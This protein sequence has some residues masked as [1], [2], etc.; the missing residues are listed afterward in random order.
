MARRSRG[1]TLIELVIAITILSMLSLLIY[2]AFSGMRRTKDGLERVGDRYRE[3][4]VAMARIARD[5]QSAYVSLH[6]PINPSLTVVKTAFIATSGT[7]ADRLDFNS[8]AN[9]RR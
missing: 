7:P 6:V 8:F 3:G 9:L 2:G 1:F 5:V 4:R